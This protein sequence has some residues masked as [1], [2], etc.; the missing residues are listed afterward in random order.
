[1]VLVELQVDHGLV[2]DEVPVI[3]RLDEAIALFRNQSDSGGEAATR[4]VKARALM[5]E[6]EFS[7]AID[8]VKP[9]QRLAVAAVLPR[10]EAEAWRLLAQLEP[11]SRGEHLQQALRIYTRIGEI[12]KIQLVQSEMER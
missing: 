8:E 4:M 10:I 9:G 7:Q 3:E 5:A 2:T 11:E 6:G 12:Q 1:M